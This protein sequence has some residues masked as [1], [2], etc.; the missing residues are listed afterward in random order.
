M[1]ANYA[2]AHDQGMM[3]TL[4]RLLGVTTVLSDEVLTAC[5]LAGM[6]MR[7]GGLG[8][9]SALRTA[10]AAY[11]AS[12]ADALPMIIARTP[13]VAGQVVASL[14]QP[15]AQAQFAVEL[16][17]SR[18]QLVDEGF[19]ACPSWPDLAAGQRPPKPEDREPGEWPHGWQ[20][21][22]SSAREQYFRKTS[23]L[24]CYGGAACAHLRSHRA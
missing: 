23:V 6:P 2:A 21:H 3:T 10:P 15:D 4:W 5:D 14:A 16:Q 8:L 22:A 24:Q 18:Q 12:W 17:A 1:S 11:W 9:R 7:S 20:Y 13:L 19:A